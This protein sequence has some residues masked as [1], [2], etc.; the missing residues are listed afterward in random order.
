M[1]PRRSTRA[2]I[3]KDF[4]LDYYVFNI[5]KNPQNLKEALTSSMLYFENRL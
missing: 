2:R 3:E 1:E 4:G 5:E